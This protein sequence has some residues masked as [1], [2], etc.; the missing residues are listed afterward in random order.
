[1]NKDG[2]D[3]TEGVKEIR[4]ARVEHREGGRRMVEVL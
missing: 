1:M 4:V 2:R 3:H